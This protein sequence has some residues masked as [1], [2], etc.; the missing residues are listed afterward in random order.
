LKNRIAFSQFCPAGV[1][2]LFA[3]CLVFCALGLSVPASA[4][5]LSITT[6]D[7]PAAA[8]RTVLA[9]YPDIINLEGEIIGAYLD[10]DGTNFVFHGFLRSPQG[11][12]TTFDAPNASADSYGTFGNG[13][14]VE[15]TTVGDYTNS[16]FNY[17]GFI[18]RQD[19]TFETYRDPDACTTGDPEGCEGTGFFAINTSG[20][21]VG[22]YVD[23]NF[24]QHALLVEPNGKVISYEAPGAG[25]APGNP[26]NISPLGDYLYQGTD[27]AGISPG[28]NEWGAVTSAYLDKN[29]VYHGYLRSPDGTF[30][31]FDAPGSGKGFT[32]GTIPI[33]LNDLG[34][35]TGFYFDSNNVNHGF[36]GRPGAFASFDPPGSVATQPESLNDFGIITGLYLDGSSVYHGFLLS[37]DG[38][39]TKIDAPGADLTPGDFNGTFPSS[40][41]LLGAITGY[42]VDVNNVSHGFVA[43]PCKQ[44]CSES[45]NDPAATNTRASTNTRQVNPASA[46]VNNPR[47]RMLRWY[48]GV[49]AQ[50]SK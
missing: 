26:N 34:V 38:N 46:V 20:V 21:I 48:R 31:T 35:I 37:P 50:P 6:F 45:N 15:G 11:V 24:V 23:K 1:A 49:G 3:I 41:N 32:Q 16:I 47:L 28:L 17:G 22:G 9:T 2:N 40:I 7:V 8:G 36:L 18:R 25:D 43:V 14:N 29:N 39:F 10:T 30:T 5:Q 44:G 13:L 27:V 42:Y 33:S 19:G 12:I 4:Q